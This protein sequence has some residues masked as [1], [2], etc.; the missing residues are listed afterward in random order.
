MP[1]ILESTSRQLLLC[2]QVSLME[3][4]LAELGCGPAHQTILALP[5]TPTSALPL[6]LR[7]CTV[8]AS[9]STA[10]LLLCTNRVFTRSLDAYHHQ[11]CCSL[12]PCPCNESLVSH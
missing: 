9:G 10:R 12:R 3:S 1:H 11:S 4:K 8:S 2:W 5:P 7:V 6:V